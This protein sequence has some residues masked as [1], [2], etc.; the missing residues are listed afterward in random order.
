M[1]NFCDKTRLKRVY[2]ILTPFHVSYLC[3]E[4]FVG[5]LHVDEH[6]PEAVAVEYFVEVVGL[7]ETAVE[8]PVAEI[9]AE[10]LVETAAAAFAE[11][12]VAEIVAVQQIA[13][14]YLAETVAV[15][16]VALVEIVVG[17]VDIALGLHLEGPSAEHRPTVSIVA[18]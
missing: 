18:N 9:A 5:R 10:V 6:A 13:E 17:L 1:L 3:G 11:I 4:L 14:D 15:L 16:G 8:V 2:K 12:V 7:A